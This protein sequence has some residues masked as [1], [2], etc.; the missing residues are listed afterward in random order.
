MLVR[1][2]GYG[3]KCIDELKVQSGPSILAVLAITDHCRRLKS[4]FRSRKADHLAHVEGSVRENG[5]AGFADIL[6][7]SLLGAELRPI[8]IEQ[9]QINFDRSLKS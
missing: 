9:Y 3:K 1:Q 6:G 8:G 5:R 7:E 2:L 4:V